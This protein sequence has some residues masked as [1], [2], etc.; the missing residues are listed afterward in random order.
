MIGCRHLDFQLN[1]QNSIKNGSLDCE[2]R[3]TVQFPSLHAEQA[4]VAKETIESTRS[5][6]DPLYFESLQLSSNLITTTHA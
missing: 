6:S 1:D 5:K 2:T 4:E 3:I